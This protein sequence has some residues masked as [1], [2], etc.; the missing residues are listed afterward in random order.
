MT[1][2]F[3]NNGVI[4]LD[5]I[6]TMGVSVKTN[7]NPIGYFGTGL[8]FAIA[9]LLRTGH[10]ITL[11][12][13][14]DLFEFRT[15]TKSIR[16]KDF[17]MVYM[18]DEQLAFTTD[19]G[20]NWKV[21][22][23]YRELHS[24]TID[25]RGYIGRNPKQLDDNSTTFMIYGQEIEEAFDNRY[26]IF[27]SS[28]PSWVVDGLEI[29]RGQSKYLYY[30]GVRVAELPKSTAFTYNFTMPMKLTE[31]RTLESMYDAQWRIGCRIPMVAD[32]EFA[33]R[34]LNP[35]YDG[36]E[37]DLDFTNCY[38]PSEEFLD[39]IETF[40]DH[41]KLNSNAKALLKEKRKA[42]ISRDSCVLSMQEIMTVNS[43]LTLL[44]A[45]NCNLKYE[46][47][48]FVENLGIGV[49]GLCEDGNIFLARAAIA[50]GSDWVASTLYE[51]WLHRQ[52]GFTDKS[53]GMQQF[54]F[55]KIFQLV[56]EIKK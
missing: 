29:H 33:R 31:D 40:K 43:A 50:K 56:K 28:D 37:S 4:D 8:K 23:A 26:E 18:G 54:L 22:Q 51:E 21:W 52:F 10:K 35:E 14:G 24:N 53:R 42:S 15:V 20:R 1:I 47:I 41:I 39:V 11:D 27:L 45:V 38:S 48:I 34:I 3:Q 49:E 13:G 2:F 5:V 17:D 7:D 19:L 36:F 30:R 32:P 46:E 9:T 12:T 25:E 16:G 44:P 55:D 6:K